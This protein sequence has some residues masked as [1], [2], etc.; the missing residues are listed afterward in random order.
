[1]SI[2]QLEKHRVVLRLTAL[3]GALA[4]LGASGC[5]DSTEAGADATATCG[6]GTVKKFDPNTGKPVCVPDTDIGNMGEDSGGLSDGSGTSDT[7]GGDTGKTDTGGGGD[8]G[9]S[10]ACKPGMTGE[11][12]WFNCPPKPEFPGGKLHGQSCTKDDEC[13]YG[14]CLFGLPL[15]AYDKAIGICSKNCGFQGTNA[16]TGC[17]TE[18]ANPSGTDA[19]YCTMER[20]AAVGNTM[21]DTS[22]PALFKMCGHNCKSD[23]DC[24]TWNPDLPTCAKSSTQALSTNPNGVCVRLP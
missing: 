20:T 24:K 7:G 22:K 10:S 16:H 9:G 18:D 3:C 4:L 23:A 15:A 6:T 21:R 2:A 13:L 11:A 5:A 19:Y 1:M 14:I 12:K 8:T 17:S